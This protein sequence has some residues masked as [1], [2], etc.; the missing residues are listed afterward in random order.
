VTTYYAAVQVFYER[1]KRQRMMPVVLL[2]KAES[3]EDAG[4]QVEDYLDTR[5]PGP[6]YFGEEYQLH[7]LEGVEITDPGEFIELTVADGLV[8]HTE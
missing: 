5:F 6:A 7:K 1:D 8:L 3:E 2:L 4:S